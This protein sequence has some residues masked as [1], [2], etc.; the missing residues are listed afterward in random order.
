MNEALIRTERIMGTAAMERLRGARIA[1]FGV[2]GVGGNCAEALARS[3][4]GTLDLI[5][6]DEVCRSNLNR[7]VFALQSTIGMKKVDAAKQ[8]LEDI[9]KEITVHTYPLF[10]LPKTRDAIDFTAFDYIVDAIDTV[11][12]KIDII[13]QAM[14]YGVPIISSMGT[15][16]RVDPSRLV[17]KDLYETKGDPLARI[18]RHELRKRGIQKLTVCCS[19][20]DPIKPLEF[21]EEETARRSVPGSTAFVPPAAGILIASYVVR[22]LTQFDPDNR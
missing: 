8:R 6:N 1:V 5:D 4:V 7:Q 20:E 12:A 15:G 17:I 18:M 13:E 9:S 10:Y 22:E 2:G 19:E 14:K 11:T 3:G 21:G 16:N